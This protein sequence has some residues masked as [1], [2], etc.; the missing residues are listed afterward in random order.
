MTVTT[1]IP[2][3]PTQR[4]VR[5]RAQPP[6]PPAWRCENCTQDNSGRRRRCMDCGTTHY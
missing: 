6:Q 1:S 2:T 4:R 5:R 3:I